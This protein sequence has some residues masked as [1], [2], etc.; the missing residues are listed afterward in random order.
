V[1]AAVT[2]DGSPV[3]A[4]LTA[5]RSTFIERRPVIVGATGL[6]ALAG[7]RAGTIGITLSARK[8]NSKRQPSK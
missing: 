5:V 6:S 1:I 3:T 2:R 7:A 4:A 8:Q